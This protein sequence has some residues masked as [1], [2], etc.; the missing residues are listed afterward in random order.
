[1]LIVG[2]ALLDARYVRYYD[3]ACEDYPAIIMY[4]HYVKVTNSWII[5]IKKSC[6]TR[7]V[8]YTCRYTCTSGHLNARRYRLN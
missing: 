2:N 5:E 4:L 6:K 3:A 7:K 8:A 1:M